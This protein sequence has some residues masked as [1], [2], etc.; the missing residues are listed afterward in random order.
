MISDE[1]P[2]ALVFDANGTMLRVTSVHEHTPAPYTVLGWGVE[3]IVR[4]VERLA[5]AGVEFIRYP[6]MNENDPHGIWTAPSGAQIAMV[7]RSGGK[8]IERHQ[9]P[10][11]L[12]WQHLNW[13][14]YAFGTL[15]EHI[16]HPTYTF[17]SRAELRLRE[18][19]RTRGWN[20]KSSIS[21]SIQWATQTDSAIRPENDKEI[22][23]SS[24]REDDA[25]EC[26]SGTTGTNNGIYNYRLPSFRSCRISTC[27]LC[28]E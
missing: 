8:Y 6:G 2:F 15:S 12:N 20:C 24:L 19:L 13:I 28:T 18:P 23:S 9:V 7:P 16:K 26:M 21:E 1:L 11:Y 10:S 5:D 22:K 4:A 25:N 27:D 14:R 17:I 3:D